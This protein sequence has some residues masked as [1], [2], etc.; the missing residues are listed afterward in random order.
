[1][2]KILLASLLVMCCT[3]VSAQVR[4]LSEKRSSGAQSTSQNSSGIRKLTVKKNAFYLGPKVGVTMTSMSNPDECVLVDGL[5]TNFSAGVAAKGRFGLASKHATAGTG[6][7]GAGIELKYKNNSVKTFG[8]DEN[9]NED[10]SLSVGY[11]EVPIFVQ[12]YPFYKSDAMNSFYI[13]AGPDLALGLSRSPKSLTVA[14]PNEE[15]SS[16]TYHFEGE[17]KNMVGND[18]RFMLGLGY[19]IPIK[20][21]KET[22]SLVGIGARYY[23]G[24][25]GLA[26]NFPCKMNTFELSLSWQFCLGKY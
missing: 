10:A 3:T 25:S 20:S 8:T 12:V 22:K 21:G 4:E 15:L 1:M 26:G 2:K 14:D 19:D 7:L 17:K 9:G 23:I 16:I 6:V 24:T 5:G 13:E 18:V 11:F